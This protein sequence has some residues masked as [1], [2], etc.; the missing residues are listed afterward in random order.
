MESL[1]VAACAGSIETDTHSR[2]PDMLVSRESSE[3]LL[4]D[5]EEGLRLMRSFR[6]IRQPAL[7]GAIIDFVMLI[8]QLAEDPRQSLT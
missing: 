8:S 1:R 6:S 4:A 5:P 2:Q 3:N 7:R